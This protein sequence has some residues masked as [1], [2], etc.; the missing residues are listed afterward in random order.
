MRR[1]KESTMQTFTGTLR[2][3][4]VQPNHQQ[5]TAPADYYLVLGEEKV[6]LNPLLGQK[7][8]LSFS[9]IIQCIQCGRATRKSFQQGYCFVCLQRLMECNLCTIHPEKCRYY[10]GICQ[11]GDW[12]HA[13]CHQPH[14]VYLA[15]SSAVKVGIT[16]QQ[17]MVTRW[18]DQG[19][20]QGVPLLTVQNRSQAGQIEVMFKEHIADKTNWRAML[21][22]DNS[23]QDL[24]GVRAELFPKVEA[25][26]S[27]FSK[28]YPNDIC[29]LPEATEIIKLNYPVLEYPKKV[30]SLTVDKNT[31][32]TATLLGMK[33]QYLI[34]DSGV[35]SIR[36]WAGYGMEF[37][38][39]CSKAISAVSSFA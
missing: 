20:T 21:K 15:N 27:Q 9:G 13:H 39:E 33:G 7:I 30:Q 23:D 3:M 16:R 32:F 14:V 19:A 24:L 28:A 10:E 34:L 8:S 18:L 38:N 36:K 12:A 22:A 11:P 25:C 29:W 2:K 17:Q 35:L 37:S 6:Y 4:M 5:P 1:V 31:A 26:I